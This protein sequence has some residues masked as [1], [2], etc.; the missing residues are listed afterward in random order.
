[1]HTE[2]TYFAVAKVNGPVFGVGSTKEAA[3]QDALSNMPEFKTVEELG[4]ALVAPEFAKNDDLFV[5]E[6]TQE[7]VDE[8]Q[9]H[10]GDLDFDSNEDGQLIP[11]A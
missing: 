11:A 5:A 7:F 6:A 3:L 8:V 10:G 4:S 2:N 9:I 1:M